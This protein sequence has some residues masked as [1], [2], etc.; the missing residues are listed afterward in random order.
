MW[1]YIRNEGGWLFERGARSDDHPLIVRFSSPESRIDLKVDTPFFSPNQDGAL[2][3]ATGSIKAQGAWRL[4]VVDHGEI[5]TGTGNS[6]LNWNGR[7][8]G[9]KLPDGEYTLRLEDASNPSSKAEGKVVIDTIAP[10]IEDAYVHSIDTNLT[11]ARE[12]GFTYSVNASAAD[13]AAG[14]VSSD[15]DPTSLEVVFPDAPFTSTGKSLKT[16]EGEYQAKY[17][18]PST[19]NKSSNKLRY[20]AFIKDR[21]GNKSTGFNKNFSATVE[22]EIQIFYEPSIGVAAAGIRA[23]SG[24]KAAVIQPLKAGDVFYSRSG[25]IVRIECYDT[26]IPSDPKFKGGRAN[27]LVTKVSS[28]LTSITFAG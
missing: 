24:S 6:D 1:L 4:S 16:G 25:N 26:W 15:I 2:D 12:V 14:G 10:K 8:N 27:Y 9:V 17:N 3:T 20:T 21:A 7:I 19:S 5:T 13:Q 23:L 22:R 28:C 11:E 18:L